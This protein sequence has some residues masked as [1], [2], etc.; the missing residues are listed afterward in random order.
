MGNIG[1]FVAKLKQMK[2]LRDC[3]VLVVEDEYFI[4]DEISRA[5]ES[6]GA[7]VL[8]PIATLKDALAFVADDN[9]IDAA[10]LDVN[11]QGQMVFPLADDLQSRGVPFVFA[12]GYDLSIMPSRYRSV[13][14]FEKPFSFEKLINALPDLA[15]G[16]N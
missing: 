1:R 13:P 7:K 5:L 14:H 15:C 6:D 10:I 12:T 11:L 16:S 2:D 4:A 8:G 3:R 9:K